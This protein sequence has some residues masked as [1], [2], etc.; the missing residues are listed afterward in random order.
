MNK[1]KQ[2]TGIVKNKFLKRDF[3][4]RKGNIAQLKEKKTQLLVILKE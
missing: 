4:Q 2:E 1:L 3:V